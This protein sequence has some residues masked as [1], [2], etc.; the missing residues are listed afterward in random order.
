MDLSFPPPWLILPPASPFGFG[1][2]VGLEIGTMLISRYQ[3]S[4]SGL[5]SMCCRRRCGLIDLVQP[6]LLIQVSD[7]YCLALDC[8]GQTFRVGGPQT[9]HRLS[10]RLPQDYR[11]ITSHTTARIPCKL[12]RRLSQD[13]CTDYHPDYPQSVCSHLHQNTPL[14]L[15][16]IP[17]GPYQT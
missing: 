1:V 2:G 4:P 16:S 13:Y 17:L 9:T 6:M 11:S 15:G 12:P 5:R 10:R 8:V 14:T 7:L 3:C